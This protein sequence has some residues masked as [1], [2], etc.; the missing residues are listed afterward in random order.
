M[1]SI[2]VS[3]RNVQK[4]IDNALKE[5]NLK[6][7]DVDIKIIDEGG[8]FRKAKVEIFYD[9]SKVIDDKISEEKN[10]EQDEKEEE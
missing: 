3:A 10:E 5:L 1:K 7:E 4:A 6:Q 2:K 8:L 9:E